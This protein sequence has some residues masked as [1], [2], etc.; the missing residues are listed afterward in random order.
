MSYGKINIFDN[1]YLNK[2]IDLTQKLFKKKISLIISYFKFKKYS[3]LI[4]FFSQNHFFQIIYKNFFLIF[5]FTF[6]IL[7]NLDIG[8]FTN[9]DQPPFPPDSSLLSDKYFYNYEYKSLGFI[10]NS[11]RPLFELIQFT[12]LFFS[13]DNEK[14]ASFVLMSGMFFL[15]FLSFY[16]LINVYFNELSRTA[17]HLSSGLF[18]INPVFLA[19]SLAGGTL[20]TVSALAIIPLF[21][22]YFLD[23]NY[24]KKYS[25]IGIIKFSILSSILSQI[26][27]H[28]IFICTLICIFI[29][30][31]IMIINDNEKRFTFFL[32]IIISSFLIF[33]TSPFYYLDISG[34]IPL[35]SFNTNTLEEAY[36]NYSGFLADVSF[37]Y[38]WTYF[39]NSLRLGTVGYFYFT[40]NNLTNL[41]GYILTFIFLF[42]FINT[43]KAKILFYSKI[44]FLIISIFF[45]LIF[46]DIN[47]VS[48]LFKLFPPLFMFRNPTKI[49]GVLAIPFFI[50][51]AFGFDY[52][53]NYFKDKSFIIKSFS[54]LFLILCII[55][56]LFPFFVYQ[57]RGATYYD[58][59]GENFKNRS[60]V[61]PLRDFILTKSFNNEWPSYL[62]IPGNYP[63]HGSPMY[64][65]DQYEIQT[66]EGISD[67]N[68]IES[69]I[70]IDDLYQSI[71][72]LND[73]KFNKYIFLTNYIIL[74]KL[75]KVNYANDSIN[76]NYGAQNI[77]GNYE[78]YY[79]FF[80]KN[81][82]LK[83]IQNNEF[84]IFEN[85]NYKG[86]ISFITSNLTNN[87][88]SNNNFKDNKGV[89]FVKFLKPGL[90][91]INNLDKNVTDL[92]LYQNYNS[93]WQ[94]KETN[95]CYETNIL[96]KFGFHPIFFSLNN[97][98]PSKNENF[99][100][101]KWN[102]LNSKK[103]I[104]LFNSF[105]KY[106]F[107]NSIIMFVVISV[108]IMILLYE[109]YFIY[110]HRP[111]LFKIIRYRR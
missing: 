94:L 26:S 100:G 98:A 19:E 38:Q 92:I 32:K 99:F 31:F 74:D 12:I 68:A 4:N 107:Y 35:V 69:K 39:I 27:S 63:D 64:Y 53:K 71:F 20:T 11:V 23:L 79:D 28:S 42:G 16:S 9:N 14:V 83:E 84:I 85:L 50:I 62:I 10:H 52:L 30:F 25:A 6:F 57:D 90:I 61:F 70:F 2:R 88:L 95:K 33:I 110:N 15:S 72:D 18:A 55:T 54:S 76:T 51:F 89:N 108:L 101:M 44:A 47:L 1:L 80:K 105:Q 36:F 97:K 103:C 24:E 77:R 75:T 66:P 43:S 81:K 67:F 82:N 46:F 34:Y 49:S 41:F 78:K 93:V 29:F 91:E 86:P 3:K 87:K 56:Y 106:S 73:T 58:N 102:N 7:N 21:I 96:I 17:K 13:M 8:N 60:Y 48:W 111:W 22:K 37:T 109:K 65:A 40:E 45:F 104:Y 5:F 59:R